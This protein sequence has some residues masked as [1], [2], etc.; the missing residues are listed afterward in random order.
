MRNIP[1]Q[2]KNKCEPNIDLNIRNKNY[3]YQK[4]QKQYYKIQIMEIKSTFWF[5][6]ETRKNYVHVWPLSSLIPISTFIIK[7][8]SIN[9][10]K[11]YKKKCTEPAPA[12]F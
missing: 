5:F 8:K 4:Y 12:Y 7:K 3:E 10:I 6:S 9:T 1:D 2:Y 11:K